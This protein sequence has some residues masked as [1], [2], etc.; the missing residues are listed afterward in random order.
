MDLNHLNSSLGSVTLHQMKSSNECSISV[1]LIVSL[2]QGIICIFLQFGLCKFPNIEWRRYFRSI[3]FQYFFFPIIFC[4]YPNDKLTLWN[5]Q[6]KTVT[7][8]ESHASHRSR[9]W[10]DFFQT[11]SKASASVGLSWLMV[12]LLMNPA[13]HQKFELEKIKPQLKSLPNSCWN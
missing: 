5:S 8:I 11:Q 12:I 6:V 3:L 9:L 1:L 2:L 13:R 10:T 7:F 4:F